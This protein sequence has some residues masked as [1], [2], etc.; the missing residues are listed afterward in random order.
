MADIDALL[1]F[2]EEVRRGTL[3]VARDSPE[4][5]ANTFAWNWGY[6][7][8]ACLIAH[9]RTG[10][11]RLLDWFVA[12]YED[13]LSYRDRELDITDDY[14]GRVTETWGSGRYLPGRWMT[15][16]TLGGRI[17]FPS[18]V[19]ARRVLA[20]RARF[21]PFV[22]A[23]KRYIAIAHDTVREYDED[24]VE[25]PEAGRSYYHMPVKGM[26]DT[27]NHVNS[28]VNCHILL[29]ELQGSARSRKL[30]TEC[31]QVFNDSLR[32]TDSG[33]YEWSIRPYWVTLKNNRVGERI[34]K[35]RVSSATALLAYKSGIVFTAGD[36][37]AFARTVTDVVLAGD[38]DFRDRV[39]L[40]A[41]QRGESTDRLAERRDNIVGFL[42]WGEFDV[43]IVERIQHI[44]DTR[45]DV[46]PRGRK[47]H[48][49]RTAIA[50]AY[51]L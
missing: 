2:A 23:A 17:V 44:V 9:E 21:E 42:P 20:D 22:A 29:A 36:M 27:I 14:R 5:R 30:A 37:R 16:I 41:G 38:N 35:A 45:R 4:N 48:K 28:L 50:Y 3:K 15:H 10:D 18:L 40:K 51:A 25:F 12:S 11:V 8:E 26:A 19:F 33:A 49:P 32:R 39:D 34:W 43:S 24:F 6:M 1:A 47:L 31:C 13:V 7:A 46:F